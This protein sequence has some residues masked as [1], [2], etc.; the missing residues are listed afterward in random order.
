MKKIFYII[1]FILVLVIKISGQIDV[2]IPLSLTDGSYTIP[3]AVGL[4]STA[5]N[6]IDPQLGEWDIPP[7][8]PAGVFE[9]RFDLAPYG[10]PGISSYK[11]YRAP[12]NPPAFPF[13]GMIEH[14]LWLQVSSPGLPINITYNIPIGA[15]MKITDQI[16]GIFLNIGPFAGQ[17]VAIIPGSYTSLFARAYLKMYYYNIGGVPTPDPIFSMS[18][19][20]LNFGIVDFGYTK[21]LPVTITNLGYPDSLYIINAV[22]SNP[23]FTVSPNVFPIIIS[24]TATQVFNITYSA[25]YGTHTDSILFI[26]NASGSPSKLKVNATTYEPYPNCHAQ[27]QNKVIVS[28]GISERW[29]RFGLDYLGT[30]FIDFQ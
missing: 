6:C 21:T 27:I 2:N 23:V 16:G 7:F 1:T 30:D 10:C 11:D 9:T 15:L 8:P 14:T 18:S 19:D 20:S 24:P 28:D 12:G 22:S 26:H 29:I 25:I 17:G 3:M 13:T 4:D 5:T